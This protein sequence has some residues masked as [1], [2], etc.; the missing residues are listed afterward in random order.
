LPRRYSKRC[1]VKCRELWHSP[2]CHQ[3]R[4][5]SGR[6]EEEARAA[7]PGPGDEERR[8]SRGTESLASG[9]SGTPREQHV[10]SLGLG[11][12]SLLGTEAHSC[13]GFQI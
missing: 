6:R 9:G 3:H 13:S 1:L 8:V 10:T 2:Q 5:G 12:K 11:W 4:V 7:A